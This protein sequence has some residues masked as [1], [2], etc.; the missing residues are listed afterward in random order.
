MGDKTNLSGPFSFL[1]LCVASAQIKFV[2][3]AFVRPFQQTVTSIFSLFRPI[4]TKDKGQRLGPEQNEKIK[5][6]SLYT[7]VYS[8][9]Y[10]L[11]VITENIKN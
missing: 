11:A 5:K 3:F 1:S 2:R 9:F 10:E 4:H 8:F 7:L 6:D